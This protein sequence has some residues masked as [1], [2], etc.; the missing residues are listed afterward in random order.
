MTIRDK[1]RYNNSVEGNEGI[2]TEWIH[3]FVE[4]LL[5]KLCKQII[6][7]IDQR[8]SKTTDVKYSRY[9]VW[10]DKVTDKI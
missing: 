7:N 1:L 8:V 2:S 4:I 3:E 10:T 5:I 6:Y 9:P